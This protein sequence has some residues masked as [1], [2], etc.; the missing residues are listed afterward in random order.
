MTSR[1]D[2]LILMFF[3]AV[4]LAIFLA[5]MTGPGF[6]FE[7]LDEA[8]NTCA[9]MAGRPS[10]CF[11]TFTAFGYDWPVNSGRAYSGAL[12]T[13]LSVPLFFMLGQNLFALRLL[14]ILLGLFTIFLSYAVV[15]RWFN[16]PV[17]VIMSAFLVLQPCF[18]LFTKIANNDT[19]LNFL[20]MAALWCFTQWPARHRSWYLYAGAFIMGLGLWTKIIFV[21]PILAFFL[22]W[23]LFARDRFHFSARQYTGMAAAFCLG[24]L[25]QIY[26]LAASRGY[27][28]RYLWECVSA[29]VGDPSRMNI[30]NSNI[31]GNLIWRWEQLCGLFGGQS[32]DMLVPFQEHPPSPLFAILFAAAVIFLVEMVF[33]SRDPQVK[34]RV[35]AVLV[36]FGVL[37]GG[38]IFTLSSFRTMHVFLTV[39]FVQIILALFV[40]YSFRYA[41]P[42][43]RGVLRCTVLGMLLAALSAAFI[44]MLAENVRILRTLCGGGYIVNMIEHSSAASNVADH[45]LTQGVSTVYTPTSIFLI[46]NKISF[47]TGWRVSFLPLTA[48]GIEDEVRRMPR[49]FCVLTFGGPDAVMCRIPGDR[50]NYEAWE[51]AVRKYGIETLDTRIFLDNSGRVNYALSRMRLPPQ[52]IRAEAEK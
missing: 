28:L 48:A 43:M 44:F 29:P 7:E 11:Q 51:A 15:L 13:Y 14:T 27:L 22:A 34:K 16:R 33:L 32:F 21:W 36:I 35:A 50:E 46:G 3:G 19:V 42:R 25:P 1:F 5:D 2:R 12:Q 41:V 24:F 39:P 18:I 26:S 10:D 38:T 52:G 45:M 37:F 8:R 17:A 6:A 30:N 9:M 4:Y 31:L 40:Y 23:V 20:V 47:L 49:E